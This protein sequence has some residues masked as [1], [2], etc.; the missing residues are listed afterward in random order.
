[1]GPSARLQGAH[2]RHEWLR[3]RLGSFDVLIWVGV[4]HCE[5]WLVNLP[6]PLLL[7]RLRAAFDFMAVVD[8]LDPLCLEGSVRLC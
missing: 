1:M 2:F 5:W 6:G 4:V 3:L 7:Y 8:L